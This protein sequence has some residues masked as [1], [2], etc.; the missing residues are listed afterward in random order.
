MTSA[1]AFLASG[2]TRR[3]IISVMDAI[4]LTG[5]SLGEVLVGLVT[6]TAYPTRAHADLVEEFLSDTTAPRISAVLDALLQDSEAQ[7]QGH[8]HGVSCLNVPRTKLLDA[9]SI[10]LSLTAQSLELPKEPVSLDIACRLRICTE[11]DAPR[12][13]FDAAT[14][15]SSA[16]LSGTTIGR[17]IGLAR[18]GRY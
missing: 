4:L 2:D 3:G 5:L 17:P 6:F 16:S 14:K 11:Q 1:A 12:S 10:L 13:C 9:R 7:A 8:E 15:Y 18:K